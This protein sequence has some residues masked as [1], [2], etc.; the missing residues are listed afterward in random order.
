M[1]IGSDFIQPEF[2]NII[3]FQQKNL[4]IF[5]YVDLKHLHGLEI[6]TIGYNVVNLE[7]TALHNLKEILEFES[8]NSYSQNPTLYF[9]YNMDREKVKELMEVDGIRCIINSNE[10]LS[11]LANG[12]KF[13]FFNKKNNQFLNYN[14][15]DRELEFENSLIKNSQDADILQETIQKIKIAAT[16]VFKELNQAGNLENLPNILVEY[17]QKYW[18]SILDF[19]SNYF[20]INIPDISGIKSKPKKP[21]KDYSDEYEVII[22]TNPV[23]GKEFI[24]LLHDYRSKKVNPAHLELE[25][26]YNPQKLYNYLRNHHWK[27]GIPKTFINEWIQMKLSNYQLTETDQSDFDFIISKIGKKSIGL[28]LPKFKSNITKN[29]LKIP[30]PVTEWNKYIKWTSEHLI[31]LEQLTSI[32]KRRDSKILSEI[33]NDISELDHKLYQNEKAKME[34]D[35]PNQ[36]P[37]DTSNKLMIVD[38]TN[39]LNLDK[40]QNHELKFKNILKVHRAV[41]SLGYEPVM[42]ADASMRYHVDDKNLYEELINNGKIIQSPAGIKADEYILEVAKSENCKFLTN[43]K[44]EEYWDEFGLDWIKKNRVTCLF[45]NNK[46]IIREEKTRK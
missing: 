6:F 35:N 44:F 1:D 11:S 28:T 33:I 4:V 45:F 43:D 19:T 41:F 36:E 17:E 42:I 27:E 20:E 29:V 12:S 9:I 38:I 32:L 21:L 10:N 31:E 8:S 14:I 5:P 23:L 30:S 13:I 3:F 22:S 15:T 18:K 2:L 26:L 34:H 40:D 37:P 39:I 24:Q 25:E 16:R 46:F 7:S